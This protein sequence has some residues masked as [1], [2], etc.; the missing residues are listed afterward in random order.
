MPP[1]VSHMLAARRA[2]QEA[3]LVGPAGEAAG[4]AGR[5][6]ANSEEVGA[7][8][9]GATTPDIRVITRWERERTHFFDLREEQHQDS[10]GGFLA[11]QPAAARRRRPGATDAGLGGRVH[12]PPG[13]G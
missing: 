2:A 3:G 4:S 8:T 13:H 1:L 10:V 9:L 7:F 12:R 6:S 5:E 11:A